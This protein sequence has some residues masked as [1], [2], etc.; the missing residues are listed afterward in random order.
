MP[1]VSPKPTLVTLN[2]DKVKNVPLPSD[3]KADKLDDITQS[4]F[5]YV[6]EH[7]EAP[8]ASTLGTSET[9]KASKIP[10]SSNTSELFEP[11]IDKPASTKL[12]E[13][14]GEVSPSILLSRTQREGRFRKKAIALG[15]DSDKFVTITDEDKR[16]SLT[17]CD[18]MKTDARMCGYAKELEE[19]PHEHMDMTVRKR[20][21]GEEV[22]H[23]DLKNEGV[24]SS[25]L[26][27]DKE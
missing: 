16:N 5:N 23:Q 7:V 4:L 3:K 8:V 1:E 15:E 12:F 26:D 24:M 27:T 22:I 25:W 10:E 9:F 21:I 6:A 11:E 19:N 14:T 18:R 13:P 17:F 2:I 20:L